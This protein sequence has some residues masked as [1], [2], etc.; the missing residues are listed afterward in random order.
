MHLSDPACRPAPS[1]K[2]ILGEVRLQKKASYVQGAR[3]PC[4]LKQA[5]DEI[6]Q[7]DRNPLRHQV[8]RAIVIA[9][10]EKTE[11]DYQ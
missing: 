10:I 3:I 5:V 11:L 4:I 1:V 8:V 2:E 7:F 6:L 9:K